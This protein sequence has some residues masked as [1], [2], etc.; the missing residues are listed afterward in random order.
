MKNRTNSNRTGFTL[1]E[2]LV[3]IAI[4]GILV[5][6]LLPA[7]QSVREAAQRTSC[8]NNIR[9]MGL[10]VQNFNSTHQRYPS[11]VTDDD[12][13]HLDGLHSGLVFLLPYLD[14]DNVYDQYDL[15]ESWRDNFA[16]TGGNRI[17]VFLCP[18]NV[19]EIE[20]NG[21]FVGQATD[22]ALSMGD[23]AFITDDQPPTGI[24]GVNS[25]TTTVEIGDGLSNTFL[26]GEAASNPVIKAEST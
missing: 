11:G 24:F 12:D 15:N 10:A 16:V 26:I 23:L 19:A 9:Q 25:K 13:D 3:V 22:Y 6:M 1:V 17:E 20:Q 7:V 18:S 8:V 21:G 5:G 4:I 2:L 14:K